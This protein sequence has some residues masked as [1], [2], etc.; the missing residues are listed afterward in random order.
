MEEDEYQRPLGCVFAVADKPYCCWDF[1]HDA[2]T[3]EFLDGIDPGYFG[4]IAAVLADQIATDVA[5]QASVALR[6][7]YQQGIETLMSLLGATAQAPAGIPAWIAK[8]GTNDLRDVISRL[9]D[10]HPLLTQC[11]RGPVSFLDL[12]EYLHRFVWTNVVNAAHSYPATTPV[13]GGVP[14][15]RDASADSVAQ[16]WLGRLS[17]WHTVVRFEASGH[18]VLDGRHDAH[19]VRAHRGGRTQPGAFNGT[20]SREPIALPRDPRRSDVYPTSEAQVETS[21]WRWS[22]ERQRSRERL[23]RMVGAKSPCRSAIGSSPAL[24]E[25]RPSYEEFRI[26]GATARGRRARRPSGTC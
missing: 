15:R 3:L 17:P 22:E 21:Q 24:T 9:R 2:R 12:S 25:P 1:D 23:R 19:R 14:K 8:C 4:T 5:M 13:G 11:G 20:R 26:T 10:T 6:A 18:L 7:T 16:M